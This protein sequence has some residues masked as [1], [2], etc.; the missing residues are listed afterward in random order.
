MIM[1]GYYDE[2]SGGSFD[3]EDAFI[4]WNEL[5]ERIEQRRLARSSPA[6]NQQVSPLQD[7]VLEAVRQRARNGSTVDE[8]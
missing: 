7:V 6:A 2:S 5:S 4:G 3:Q 8:I 1:G